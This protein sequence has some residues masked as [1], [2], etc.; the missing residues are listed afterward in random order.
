MKTNQNNTALTVLRWGMQVLLE[1][2]TFEKVTFE[3]SSERIKK[4][5]HGT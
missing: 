4:G 3:E 5:N 1:T 2:A